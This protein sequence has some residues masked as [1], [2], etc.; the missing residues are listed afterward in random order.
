[1]GDRNS[2]VYAVVRRIPRGRVA[3]YGQVAA[4]AGLGRQARQVGYALHA[5]PQGS[6]VPWHRVVNAQGRVSPRSTHGPEVEQRIRLELEGVRFDAA[7]RVAMAQF[8]WLDGPPGAGGTP[9]TA[10]AAAKTAKTAK[11]TTTAPSGSA[12]LSKHVTPRPASAPATPAPAPRPAA[13][14]TRRS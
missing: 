5:L 11:A 13:K 7:G 8:R 12:H 1:M 2:R 3:S 6:D 14:R 10:A 4:W 9:A